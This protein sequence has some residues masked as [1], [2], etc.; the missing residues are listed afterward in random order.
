MEKMSP[1]D[2]RVNISV[3]LNRRQDLVEVE[4]TTLPGDRVQ[5]TIRVWRMPKANTLSERRDDVSEFKMKN[6]PSILAYGVA[7]LK[8]GDDAAHLRAVEQVRKLC[9]EGKF[10][11]FDFM[12]PIVPCGTCGDPTDMLGTERCDRCWEAEKRLPDY[13]KVGPKA[14]AFVAGALSD[15]LSE[16]TA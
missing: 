1:H 11:R 9:R 3:A 5:S 13:L 15:H 8:E 14:V 2:A 12:T 4:A 6:R 7:T 16:E 10:V